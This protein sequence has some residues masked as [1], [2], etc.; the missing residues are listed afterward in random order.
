MV[1]VGPPRS[2]Q[3]TSDYTVIHG[4]RAAIEA[5]SEMTD[6][7]KEYM[8]K[9]DTNRVSN[10]G[11]VICIS[12]A[13]DNASMNSLEKIFLQVLM[14]QNTIASKSEHLLN[15]DFC[16]LV[17]INLYP[18]TMESL[19]TT[20]SCQAISPIL[21]SEIHSCPAGK[22]PKVLM[23]LILKHYNLASTTVTNIPMKEEQNS[24]S[25]ANYDVEIFHEARSHSVFLGAELPR[26]V[27]EGFEYET[28]TLK[29]CTPRSGAAELQHCL[30]QNRITPV[31]VTSRPSSCLINF[32]LSGRS[33][34]LEMPKKS[35]GKATSHLLTA[36]GGEIFIHS[37]NTTRSIFEEAPS[38]SELPGGKVVNYRI[39]DFVQTISQQRL[40][41]LKMKYPDENLGKLR[42]RI[43]RMTKYW[44]ITFNSTIV[45]NIRQ[46][47]DSILILSQK[48][49]L[50]DEEVLAC[51]QHI[52][53]LVGF[54]TSHDIN[55]NNQ[56]VKGN[57]KDDQYRLM[58]NELEV[59]VGLNGKS[60]KHKAILQCIRQVRAKSNSDATEKVEDP[61]LGSLRRMLDGNDS[62]SSSIN[63]LRSSVDSPLSPTPIERHKGLKH[64][65]TISL[66][67][68]MMAKEQAL[69]NKRLDFSGRLATPDGQIAVLYPHIVSKEAQNETKI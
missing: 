12:S 6:F 5:I 62:S 51:Q 9:N 2:L 58:W 35:G 69:A 43:A 26:S 27:K 4:L 36:H 30:V 41:P 45:Y 49:E 42:A 17:I 56:R 11:R 60:A 15:I 13:R 52:Y 16:H 29:W 65:A 21:R 38:I 34:L 39:T 7:Q 31:D 64:K 24:S 20:R 48:E 50:T 54:E 25:S 33:V 40:V 61:A 55:L 19:V 18:S 28:V 46:Y 8:Q 37:L 32:L 23:S 1:L 57:K 47:V 68:I 53:Q 44:P 14:Q 63:I 67:D 10:R 66:Y 22:L 3:Q 59:I